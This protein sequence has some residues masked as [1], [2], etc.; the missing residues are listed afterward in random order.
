MPASATNFVR[1]SSDETSEDAVL[2]GRLL[3]RQP[4]RGHRFGHDAI[5][6]AAATAAQEG[7]RAVELG[8]GV[9]VAGLALARRIAGLDVT[10]V[11]IDPALAALARGNAARN[12]LADRVHAVCLDVAAPEAAFAAAGLAPASADRVLMNPPFNLPQNPSPD[13]GRRL[14]RTASDDT[15]PLW[16][17]T[18]ARLLRPSGVATLIW[19]ADALAG[20]LAALAQN[21]GAIVVLPIHPKP[22]ASAIR[23]LASAVKARSGP[24][25][26]L[27]GFVLADANGRPT[28]QAETILRDGAALPLTGS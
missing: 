12:G 5:L 19:R 10:L 17:A 27:P 6:L 2:G 8:A 26:R 15:L 28:A 1:M 23:V 3:L 11:E 20:V 21:F 13:R 22:G 7:E 4:L 16:L 18:A 9:G 14:A 25:S 24:L